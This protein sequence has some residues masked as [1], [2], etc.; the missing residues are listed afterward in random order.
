MKLVVSFYNVSDPV[1]CFT[2]ILQ[3]LM[4]LL[5]PLHRIRVKQRVTPWAATIN[6]IS[7]R[8][9]RDGLHH[10]ALRTGDPNIWQQYWCAHNKANKLLRNAK[11]NYLS[12]LALSTQGGSKKF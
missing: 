2:A 10:Q 3:G 12:Q 5:I 8:R 6:V 9:A 4:D 11:H 7:A 1:E